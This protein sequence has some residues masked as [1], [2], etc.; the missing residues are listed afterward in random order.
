MSDAG[1]AHSREDIAAGLRGVAA[2]IQS[3]RTMWGIPPQ[4]VCELLRHVADVT[5]KRDSEAPAP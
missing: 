3:R 2:E 1:Y 4:K 5:V